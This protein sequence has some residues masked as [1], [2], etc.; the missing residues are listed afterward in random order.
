[1][2]MEPCDGDPMMPSMFEKIIVLPQGK[3]PQQPVLE[4][5][6]LCAS[7]SAELTVLDIFYEP[8]LE[9]YLGNREVYE[10]LRSRVLAERQQYAEALA[11]ALATRGI[12]A[13]GKA[14]WAASRED[15][16]EEY[17]K[18]REVDLVV[19][20]PL[21]GG[22]GGL[23]SS[24]WRLL[25]RCRAPVLIVRGSSARQY[26]HIVAAVDPFHAHAKPAALDAD[27]LAAAAKL[28]AK[29]G[30]ELTVLHC[31]DPPEFFRAD[32]RLAVR[33]SEFEGGRRAELE[34]LLNRAGLPVAAAK[35]VAGE[36]HSI[37]HKMIE[38]GQ[39]D[40]IVMGALARGRVKDWVIG[41]TAER[42]LHRTQVDVLAV[43]PRP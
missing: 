12:D 7:R 39:A 31:F 18:S 14:V 9:G 37:L 40:L 17:A 6:V 42:V 36:P 16:I 1:M 38:A 43:H 33:D 2:R 13:V 35:V 24:D 21:D 15:A 29:T 28:Q 26:K 19:A 23:A 8:A 20:A 22:R 10:P 4:R 25:S 5:A 3:D 41:S 34:A 11:A 27:I 30:A 32:A